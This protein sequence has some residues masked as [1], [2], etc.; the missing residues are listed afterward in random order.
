M[1]N[2]KSQLKFFY[3]L[4]L[5]LLSKN[6]CFAVPSDTDPIHSLVH[7][8]VPAYETHLEFQNIPSENGKDVFELEGH[9][10]KVIIRGNNFNS[11]AVGLNYFLKYYCLTE[12]SWYK[13]DTVQVPAIMPSVAGKVRR[14]ARVKKRFFFNYCTFGYTMPW[15]KWEDW[16]RCIDWMALNGVNMPLA[17]TGEEA[18][19][20]KVW[21]KF[22][23]NNEQI[24]NYFTGPAYLPWH[25]MANIDRW[26]GPLPKSWIN[27]QLKLQKKI[28]ARERELSMTPVLPAFAGH[29]P[30]VLKEKFPSAKITSLG[31]WGGFDKK[32]H[33]YFLDPLDSLFG[34]IQTAY[35]K[36]QTRLLGTDHIYGTDPFNEVTPPSWEPEY[37]SSVS[38]TIYKTMEDADPKATWLQMTWLFYIDKKDWTNPR[39]EAFLKGVPQNKMALL[40]Y[41]AEN[42]EVWKM[43]DKYYGQ[44]YIWCYLGN[45]GGNTMLA[46][47]LEEVEKRMEN[48]FKNGGQNLLGVG[49]TLEGFDVNPIM[50]EYVFE[51][52]WSAGAV[53]VQKWV[54]KYSARRIGKNNENEKAAWDTLF[55]TAYTSPTVLGQSTLTNAQPSFTGH[56]NWTTD[57]KID[58][59]NSDLMKAWGL[60]LKVLHPERDAYK[61]DIVNIGRQVLGNYFSVL[62]DKFTSD[63]NLKNIVA[64]KKDKSQMLVLFDD[65]DKLLSTESSFLLGRWL[66]QAKDFGVN[67]SEKKYY[68]HDAR[69]IIT[70]WGTKGQSLNDYANRS[71]AGLMKT[72]YK[73]RW[74]M[75]MDQAISAAEKKL[76]FDEQDFY[77]RAINFEIEWTNKNDIYPDKPSGNAIQI[78]KYLYEKYVR[79]I[80]AIVPSNN[81]K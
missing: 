24:C 73:E 31:D 51:K 76:A 39:M 40:D 45:F 17:T 8:I 44:P 47:N 53:D 18:I 62:R 33:S 21:E 29:I 78:A 27:N 56:G 11:M 15:W 7:R 38:K 32:Y 81:N 26:E 61:Y 48:T 10:G 80:E 34:V 20:Y 2:T 79:L 12:V 42:T 22:G 19:W 55:K 58:Y 13:D 52:V 14:L 28:L 43:T 69:T 1:L 77:Q 63:Y 65:M 9:N 37:L 30:E 23:L 68:E 25:R 66:Q 50:Y 6:I 3:C 72:Y 4:L 59:Q 75:F 57:P 60:L 70:T 54:N 35:L 49:S 5:L 41:F 36:E 64:L 46:G 67:E 71:W 74:K 16:E